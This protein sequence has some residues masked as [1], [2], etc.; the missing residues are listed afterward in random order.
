MPSSK[1]KLTLISPTDLETD[2][3]IDKFLDYLE[4]LGFEFTPEPTQE[5]ITK[6]HGPGAPQKVHG[7]KGAGRGKAQ[8]DFE[9]SVRRNRLETG[10]A[11]DADGKEIW[12]K[13]GMQDADGRNMI[14]ISPYDGWQLAGAASMSHNHPSGGS[15]S[16]EDIAFA[17]TSGISEVRAVGIQR[18][19]ETTFTAR[20]DHGGK[21]GET[22]RVIGPMPGD[23][24]AISR[25]N[26]DQQAAFNRRGAELDRDIQRRLMPRVERGEISH[27]LAW[28]I[29]HEEKWSTL[30]EE[31]DWFSYARETT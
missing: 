28:N 5:H 16:E 22:T 29:H 21:H 18:G 17:L 1:T 12:R 6:G 4:E 20:I 24:R 10:A 13:Q 23:D 19:K 31:F 15:F 3:G 7:R 27:A 26:T 30:D 8:T 9:E 11:Y 14:E 25:I 2:E